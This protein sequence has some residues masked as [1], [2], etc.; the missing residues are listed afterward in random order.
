[1]CMRPQHAPCKFTRREECISAV[2]G[3]YSTVNIRSPKEQS[4]A[5][6]VAAIDFFFGPLQSGHGVHGKHLGLNYLK[7]EAQIFA[8]RMLM[9]CR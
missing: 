9:Y 4:G 3:K 1:M 2:G 7:L 6:P 5:W 8:D